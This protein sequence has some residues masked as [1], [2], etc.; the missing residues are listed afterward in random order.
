MILQ[1]SVPGPFHT[2]PEEFENAPITGHLDFC[3]RR[4]RAGKSRDYRKDVTFGKFRFRNVSVLLKPGKAGVF[5]F[6]RFQE[7]DG[8]VWRADLTVEIKWRF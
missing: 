5:K 8:L 2:A 1:S 6:L 4:T 7:R 3:L